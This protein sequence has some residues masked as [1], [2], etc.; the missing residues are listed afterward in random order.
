MP[1]SPSGT[2]TQTSEPWSEQKPYLEGGFD[3][4]NQWMQGG[5]PNYY[6]GST[7]VDFGPT[8]MAGL[9]GMQDRAGGSWLEQAG[10]AGLGGTMQGGNLF[11]NPAW[12]LGG[13]FASGANLYNDPRFALG[14]NQAGGGEIGYNPLYGYMGNVAAGGEVGSNPFLDATYAR[15]A[16]GLTDQYRLG[17]LPTS[18]SQFSGGGRSLEHGAPDALQQ[19][20][21]IQAGQFGDALGGLATDIYGGAYE[22][23]QRRRMDAA[24][25]IGGTFSNEQQMRDAMI[26]QFGGAYRGGV[27]DQTGMISGLGNIFQGERGLQDQAFYGAPELSQ[28]IDYN[29]LDRLMGTGGM[30]DAKSMEMLT[31]DI[32]RFNFGENIDL[33]RLN[34]YMGLIGGNYGGETTSA[35]G[36]GAGDLMSM[37]GMGIGAYGMFG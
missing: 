15:A 26:G 25:G 2:T 31:D 7:F 14:G 4:T 16:E 8:T 9:Q 21:G 11:S 34:A 12:M 28:N 6:P 3:L 27:G 30:I 13:D 1:D 17:T 23:D 32:N 33:E 24:F 22:N 18:L 35:R 10:M 19:I 20:A 5:Q 36:W 29:N 37:V